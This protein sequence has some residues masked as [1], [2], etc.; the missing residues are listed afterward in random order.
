M[1]VCPKQGCGCMEF[2]DVEIPLE[3]NIMGEHVIVCKRCD[4]IIGISTTFLVPQ[5]G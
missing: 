4:T 5:K 1:P 2:K 3:G